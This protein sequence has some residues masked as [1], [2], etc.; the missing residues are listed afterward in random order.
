MY[1]LLFMK[2]F[3]ILNGDCL[4]EQLK[5]T[6]LNQEFI[7]CR[8]CLIDGNV[9]GDGLP[10]FWEIRA[11]FI[12]DN[13][14]ADDYYQKVVQELDKIKKLPKGPDVCLWFE[15]DLFCQVNMWFMLSLLPKQSNLKLYRVF[16]VIENDA[17][18]WKGFGIATSE[19]LEK[20][21]TTKVPFQAQDIELGVNLWTAY[22]S[23]DYLKLIELS[24]QNSNC[25]QYLEEVCQAHIDRF[26]KDNSL[27]RP[28]RVIKEIIE[29]TQS[30]DFQEVFAEFS[31]REGI[32][33]FGDLQVK[34]IFER[35]I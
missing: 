2:T 6:K 13:F 23:Q 30:K 33:G 7:I 9:S 21:Y 31:A 15:N 12:I 25:F 14:G 17:D 19:T 32:Y 10:E 22:Q 8:E 16:P 5:A 34:K 35:L 26:P 24:K 18:I 20:A 3:N 28:E 4:A 29:E 1:Q 27:G 11:K